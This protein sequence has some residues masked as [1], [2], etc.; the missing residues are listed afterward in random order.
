MEGQLHDFREDSNSTTEFEGI[1]A[2]EGSFILGE[3]FTQVCGGVLWTSKTT[4]KSGEKR[5]FSPQLVLEKKKA[6]GEGLD[7]EA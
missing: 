5:G 7:W 4:Q 3:S 2:Q 6:G 1:L